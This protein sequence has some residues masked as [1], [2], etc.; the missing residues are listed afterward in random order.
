VLGIVTLMAVA[1]L[2]LLF[3]AFSGTSRLLSR[4]NRDLRRRED[5]SRSLV[6]NWIDVQLIA[7]ATG[8]ITYESAAVERVRGYRPEDRIGR[9]SL[10]DVHPDDREWAAQMVRDVVLV[11]G[12]QVAAEVRVRH[13]DGSWLVIEAVAKNLLDDP[14]VG[15][16]VVNYRDVTGRKSLEDELESQRL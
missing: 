5:R 10:D 14:A 11:P 6:R 7:D 1:L 13:A 9:N 15:G 16:V 8:R 4:Q 2:V 3:L 12:S